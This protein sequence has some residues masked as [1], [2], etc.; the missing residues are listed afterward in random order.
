MRKSLFILFSLLLALGSQGWAQTSSITVAGDLVDQAGQGLP[1]VPVLIQYVGNQGFSSID[2]TFTDANGFFADTTV[3]SPAQSGY[4]LVYAAVPGNC[5]P[6]TLI[7]SAF[8]NTNSF[9]YFPFTLTVNCSAPVACLADFTFQ[10]SAANPLQV[11]FTNQSTASS[12]ADYFWSFG[13]GVG[14]SVNPNPSYT[15]AQPGTYN[16]YLM[17]EDTANNC[18]DTIWKTV[19][20]LSNNCDA[21]FASFSYGNGQYQFIADSSLNSPTTFYSWSFGD[22]DSLIGFNSTPIHQYSTNGTYHVC[23]L[24][25]DTTANCSDFYCDTVVVNSVT[26]SCQADFSFQIAG[27]TPSQVYFTNQSTASPGATYSWSFGDGSSGTGLSPIHIYGQ[28]GTYNVCLTVNDPANGCGDTIC[29]TVVIPAVT[30]DATFSGFPL[31]NGQYQFAS[32]SSQHSPNSLYLWDFGDGDTLASN[33]PTPIHQYATNGSFLVCLT[34]IDGSSGCMDTHC[35]TVVVTNAPANCQATFQYQFSPTGSLILT[36]TSQAPAST[37]VTWDMGDGTLL[38]GDTVT[39]TYNQPGSYLVC[40]SLSDPVTGCADTA[41]QTIGVPAPQSCSANFTFVQQGTSGHYL[42]YAVDSSLHNFGTTYFWDFGDGSTAVSTTPLG[43]NTYATPGSYLVCLTVEDS[44]GMCVDSACHLVVYPGSSSCNVTAEFTYDTLGQQTISFTNLSTGGSGPQSLQY[45]WDFG[46]STGTSTQVNPTYTYAQPG[47]YIASLTA[48][49]TATNCSEQ[50]FIP[51]IVP[52]VSTGSCDAHFTAHPLGGQA[53]GFSADFPAPGLTYTWNFGDGSGDTLASSFVHYTYA[54]PGLYDVCLTVF[55]SL[56]NCLDNVCMQIDAT[57]GG[58]SCTANF[59]WT[60]TG[61]DTYQFTNL[62]TSQDSTQTVYYWDFGDSTFSTATNPTHT[63]PGP[64]PWPVCLGVVDSST[65]CFDFICQL[66]GDTN[67]VPLSINGMVMQNNAPALTGIAYLIEHDSVA[68]TLTL[69]DST[70]IGGSAYQFQNVQPGTYLVKAALL[71]G[72]PGYSSYMPTYLGDELFWDD[73]ISTVVTGF[74]VVNPDLNLVAGNNPGGPGFIGGLV[75]QGANKQGDPMH[76]VSILLLG[77]NYE[78]ITHTTTHTDGTFD[79]P[80]LAYGTYHV[81]VEMLGRYAEAYTVTLSPDNPSVT[82]I[83]FEVTD[84]A[85]T[86]TGLDLPQVAAD[87]KVFPN[88]T[89]GDLTLTW[90]QTESRSARLRLLNAMGQ[91]VQRRDLGMVS[92][93][94]EANLSLSTLPA[95]IYLLQVEVGEQQRTLRVTRR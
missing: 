27:G 30:C 58:V 77:E 20:I 42:F 61:P 45:F 95:G 34:V 68:G 54:Q 48:T 73:A 55:D 8:F 72:T 9:Q 15:Y 38:S 46:D 71:P 85:V 59:V 52:G 50:T 28:S 44:A 16:A 70:F 24:V 7:D 87:L 92:G 79:L 65:G 82:D 10:P 3:V 2:S 69:V 14:T 31:N 88:P 37:V 6:S 63:F 62:S 26:T 47:L 84:N 4:L 74:P 67:N 80:N 17:V 22:G 53:F 25:S 83:E 13:D 49:D 33:D 5:S 64:G 60:Q 78:A 32:D 29:K 57:Q 36:N 18:A 21:T 11:Q 76:N 93:P 41:C 91:T 94:V 89:E 75:A 43:S 56:N 12:T 35:D 40:L 19:T 66:V 81:F 23:L 90:T 51:V 1:G 39:Y 86:V